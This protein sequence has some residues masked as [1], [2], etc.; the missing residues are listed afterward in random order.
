MFKVVAASDL[1][2][3]NQPALTP[4]PKPLT[5]LSKN[6]Y[7]NDLSKPGETWSIRLDLQV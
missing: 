4:T 3:V 2:A 7:N 5:K 6:G 1:A